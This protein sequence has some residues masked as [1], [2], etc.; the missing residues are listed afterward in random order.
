[1][2]VKAVRGLFRREKRPVPK[3]LQENK[4]NHKLWNDMLRDKR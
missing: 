1:M 4:L 2:T 3:F